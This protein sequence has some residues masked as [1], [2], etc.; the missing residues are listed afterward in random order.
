MQLGFS[1][2]LRYRQ[3]CGNP[4]VGDSGIQPFDFSRLAWPGSCQRYCNQGEQ[5]V[6]EAPRTSSQIDSSSWVLVRLLPLAEPYW[7]KTVRPVGYWG[8]VNTT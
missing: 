1:S 3:R 8:I 6:E 2:P 7:L 4:D 5:Q